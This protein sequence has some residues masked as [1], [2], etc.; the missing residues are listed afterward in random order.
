M[1]VVKFGLECKFTAN[2]ISTLGK[3]KSLVIAPFFLSS[4]FLPFSYAFFPGVLFVALLVIL[5]YVT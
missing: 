1:I 4:H 5:L 3:N 2:L